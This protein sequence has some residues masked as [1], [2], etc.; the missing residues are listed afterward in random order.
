MKRRVDRTGE[1]LTYQSETGERNG[2][3]DPGPITHL[4]L[5]VGRPGMLFGIDVLPSKVTRVFNTPVPVM[6][7]MP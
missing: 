6:S 3:H 2:C 7:T 5:T 1:T 4:G